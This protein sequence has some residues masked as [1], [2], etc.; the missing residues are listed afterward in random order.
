V[1]CAEIL[2]ACEGGKTLVFATAPGGS[3]DELLRQR[4]SA[5]RLFGPFLG[6]GLSTAALMRRCRRQGIRAKMVNGATLRANEVSKAVYE[7]FLPAALAV[8]R[9][10]AALDTQLEGVSAAKIVVSLDA[11]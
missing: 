1:P 9:Y 11:S 7:D 6:V 8:G 5:P 10:Q 2:G 3:L 4:P